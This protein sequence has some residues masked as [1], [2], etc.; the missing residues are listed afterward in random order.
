MND[1]YTEKAISEMTQNAN[2]E[3][4]VAGNQGLVYVVS[5]ELRCEDKTIEA[6]QALLFDDEQSVLSLL[7]SSDYHCMVTYG[8]PHN[9]P[10]IQYGTFV[11]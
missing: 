10:I 8:V 1:K 11:D 6:T 7:A 9:E 4:N 2:H 5:G 3:L